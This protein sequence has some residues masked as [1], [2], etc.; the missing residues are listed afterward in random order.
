VTRSGFDAL[1]DLAADPGLRVIT[2][3]PRLSFGVRPIPGGELVELVVASEDTP[4]AE[5]RLTPAYARE[6]SS[7]L[8]AAADDVDQGQGETFDLR[9]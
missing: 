6:L 1:R 4:D 7:A 8:A 9:R 3:G 5:V 2:P